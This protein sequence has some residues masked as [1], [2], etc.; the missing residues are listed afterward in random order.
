MK[1]CRNWIIFLHNQKKI[2]QYKNK[3]NNKLIK[4]KIYLSSKKLINK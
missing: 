2:N 4:I 1:I 3:M